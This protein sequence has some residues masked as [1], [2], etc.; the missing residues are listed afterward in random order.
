MN[1]I[2]SKFIA[3]VFTMGTLQAETVFHLALPVANLEGVQEFY[4]DLGGEC[5]NAKEGAIAFD[6][7]GHSV[8]FRIY[9]EY[10]LPESPLEPAQINNH[11]EMIPARHFGL[12][13]CKDDF[14][15]IAETMVRKDRP[16]F[17]EPALIRPGES[18][19]IRFMMIQDPN[20]YAVEI[21]SHIPNTYLPIVKEH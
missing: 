5:V 14:E 18:D 2:V 1:N 20:G 8:V 10:Q 3:A 19:E 7:Y 9:E 6:L 21:K 15:Q 13:I 17:V 4:E 16:F 11:L 12:I